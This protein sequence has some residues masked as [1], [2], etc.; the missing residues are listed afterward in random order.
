[1]NLKYVV[2]GLLFLFI[3]SCKNDCKEK[4]PQNNSCLDIYEPVCGCDG[5][6]Y[7]NS[8]HAERSGIKQYSEGK[9]Q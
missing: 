8:C 4:G 3:I 7:G 9:C 5:E 2:V 1:M 6:T